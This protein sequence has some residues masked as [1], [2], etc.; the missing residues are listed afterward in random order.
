MAL[1]SNLDYP[2]YSIIRTFFLWS[3]FFYEYELVVILKTQSCKKPNNPFKRLLKQRIILCAFRLSGT[4]DYSGLFTEV[5]TSPDNRGSTVISCHTCITC[6]FL[7]TSILPV[8]LPVQPP[9][10][11]NHVCPLLWFYAHTVLVW[12][13]M[14]VLLVYTHLAGC[15]LDLLLN[16]L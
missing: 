11:I 2:D 13:S 15:W 4:L 8:C 14:P 12:D 6:W 16:S 10:S 7:L 5:P 1:Q 3:Q 9:F